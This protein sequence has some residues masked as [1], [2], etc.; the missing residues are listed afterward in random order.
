MNMKL[1]TV[2][3]RWMRR[4][5]RFTVSRSMQRILRNRPVTDRQGETVRLLGPD[6]RGLP[7]KLEP[8]AEAIR[9][10]A[11]FDRLPSFGN[12]L[13]VEF[14]VYTAACDRVMRY[15]NIDPADAR[16][17][18]SD[19]GW[20]IYRRMLLVASLPFQLV[21]RDSGKRIR[22]TIQLLLRFPFNAPGAPGYEVETRA[23][24]DKILTHF[25]NCPPQSYI[26]RLSAETNDPDALEAFRESWYLYDW[27]G[28]DV[29]AGDG[30]RG[31][32]RRSQTLSRGD[33]VCDMCWAERRSCDEP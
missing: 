10:Y 21:T 31:H 19:A 4:V 16:A 2:K 25:R 22:W 7:E 18:F 26:R 24:D 33:P 11:E 14:A 32:Y 1:E 17:A 23:E 3:V 8:E 13:M 20:H 9:P 28:A 29:I 15:S 5:M 27:P 6:I 12:R 30:V